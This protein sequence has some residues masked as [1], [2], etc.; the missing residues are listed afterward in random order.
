MKKLTQSNIICGLGINEAKG[1]GNILVVNSHLDFPKVKGGEVV[2]TTNATPDFILILKKIKCL[3]TDEGGLTCHIAIV[4][5]EL[6][7]PAI[8]ATGNATKL[9]KEGDFVSF[10]TT[11][12]NLEVIL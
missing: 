8:L 9:L 1:K 12:G 3:V 7:V 10:D 5:R 4:C 11:S 6:G 2:I